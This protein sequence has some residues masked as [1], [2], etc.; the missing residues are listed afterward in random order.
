M[1]MGV[2]SMFR[3]GKRKQRLERFR[4]IKSHTD[5]IQTRTI[6]ATHAGNVLQHYVLLPNVSQ[7]DKDSLETRFGV[8]VIS[9]TPTDDS[10]PEVLEFI[11]LLSAVKNAS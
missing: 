7:F 8:R 10:H 6:H 1:N 9:Y 4:E 2:A 11:R 3:W 5:A